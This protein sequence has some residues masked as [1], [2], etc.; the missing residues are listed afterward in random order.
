MVSRWS[1][2]FPPL[3]DRDICLILGARKLVFSFHSF[4]FSKTSSYLPG[5]HGLSRLK[6]LFKS[7]I[8]K[9]NNNFPGGLVAKTVLPML[10]PRFDPWLGN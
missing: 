7:S 2:V 1:L 6:T 5:K 8:L 9:N 10:G 3:L 4:T